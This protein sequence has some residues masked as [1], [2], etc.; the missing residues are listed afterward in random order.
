MTHTV[1]PEASSA[2]TQRKPQARSLERRRTILETTRK[3]LESIPVN[4]L[5]L[6]QVADKA[7]IPP[8]SLYH[9]FPKLEVL[10]DALVEDIFSD[11][12]AILDKPL[13]P[14][15]IRHWSDI[16]RQLQ[17][18]NIAYYRQHK[19]VRNLILG[20]HVGSSI[21]HADYDH[22]NLLG[23]RIRQFHEQFYQLPTLPTNF[24]IFAIAIQI[25]DKVYSI[26]HQE[27]GNISEVMAQEGIRASIAYLSSYLPQHMNC[28]EK[29]SCG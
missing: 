1:L 8:S 10:L 19:Y 26:S 15:R 13:D 11:F 24:N 25:A 29:P 28:S 9:F 18:R 7:N 16:I 5:S 21:S 27:F 23:C 2:K 3:L 20:Q 12:D 6:Y 22:D 14:E 17:E 4:E